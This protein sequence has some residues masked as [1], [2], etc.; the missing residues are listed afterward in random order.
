MANHVDHKTTEKSSTGG[1]ERRRRRVRRRG[2]RKH[3]GVN[4]GSQGTTGSADSPKDHRPARDKNL[5]NERSRTTNVGAQH[6]D[7]VMPRRRQLASTGATGASKSQG[8]AKGS[9]P[10]KR[11]RL[12][13]IA[14]IDLGT[15]NCRLLVAQAD[16]DLYRQSRKQ[17]QNPA[18]G[19]NLKTMRS[20][21]F[22][23]TDAFSRIVRLGEGLASTGRLTDEAIDRTITALKVCAGKVAKAQPVKLDAVATE[24][25]RRAENGALFLERVKNEV[26]I[27][28]R[29]ISGREEAEL[30]LKSCVPLIDTTA[31]MALVFD[32]GG[33]STEV[34]VIRVSD[35]P[36]FLSQSPGVDLGE[37]AGSKFVDSVSAPVGVVTFA[38]SSSKRQDT[39][40]TYEEMRVRVREHFR[41]LA[42]RHDLSQLAQTNKLCVIGTGGTITTLKALHL[43]L[44]SY[45]RSQVDATQMASEEW[46]AVI[47]KIGAMSVNERIANG[48]IGS[49]RADLVMPGCAILEGMLDLWPAS[50]VGV[51][52]RGLREGL[53]V[54][55]MDRLGRRQSARRRGRRGRARRRSL[56]V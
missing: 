42:E 12:P 51:A 30:A 34:S 18:E 38:E 43:G 39:S 1:L 54:T 49:G 8:N 5:G 36:A 10:K 3:N 25:C 16:M 44:R 29:I 19:A 23:I 15:N 37:A 2:D 6:G 47:A 35:L 26:G 4:Q 40:L 31:E 22:R 28:L 24:A 46:R 17:H 56:V 11:R 27:N 9:P 53:L 33:G 48:C 21:V 14:A 41:D 55:M 7:A 13:I 20:G 50:R 45:D 52:D 32:I